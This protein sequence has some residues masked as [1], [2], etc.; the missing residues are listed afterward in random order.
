MSAEKRTTIFLGNVNMSATSMSGTSVADGPS[1][2]TMYSY[3]DACF[4]TDANMKSM[5]IPMFCT[6]VLAIDNLRI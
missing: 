5:F 6:G 4:F 1:P 2:R 3:F